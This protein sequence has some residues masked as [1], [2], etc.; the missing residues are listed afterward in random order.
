LAVVWQGCGGT[1]E[2][3]GAA[4]LKVQVALDLCQGTLQGPFLQS[5]RSQDRSAP[6]QSLPLP[7]GALRLSDLGFFSLD[8][9]QDIAA[10]GAFFLSRL[11][12]QTV[13]YVAEGQRVAALDL[14][15]GQDEVDLPIRMGV[16][17]RLPVRLLAARVSAE[18]A[19]E[20]R[21]KLRAEARHKGQT[22]SKARLALADWTVYVTNVPRERLSLGEALVLA[23]ARWQVELLFK[24]WKSGGCIDEWRSQKPWR[25]LCEVYAKLLAVVIQHWLVLTGIWAYPERSW[26]KAAGTVRGYALMLA[27]GMAG[28]V[29]LDVVIT[30]IVHCLS[31]GCRMNPRRQ[32]P[33]T[34]Q[35]LLGL[36]HAA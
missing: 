9:L 24:L 3:E 14:L 5:G 28:V 17:H 30:Q 27:S 35:L 6:T 2:G 19:N 26:V 23:R 12:V 7:A 33:N 32:H 18:A 11:Q 34:Y 1:H 15:K 31:A 29:D 4:A 25:I 10:K 13:L 21:R 16:E 8:V 20:R 22:V 36:E